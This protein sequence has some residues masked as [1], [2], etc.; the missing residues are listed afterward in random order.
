M[1]FGRVATLVDF[2]HVTMKLNHHQSLDLS[3]PA[4]GGSGS[5]TA[6]IVL[7]LPPSIIL[8]AQT[9]SEFQQFEDGCVEVSYLGIFVLGSSI[10]ITL[11]TFKRF[12]GVLSSLYLIF[13]F[14]KME[15]Q[16][17]PI[18]AVRGHRIVSSFNI[19]NVFRFQLMKRQSG[20]VVWFLGLQP[21]GSPDFLVRGCGAYAQSR[22]S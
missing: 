10:V 14:V 21:T 2:C 9:W 20:E 3:R 17:C 7:F 11:P 22:R 1:V 12:N 16:R 15:C 13:W 4:C 8:V 5:A 18:S 6:G 19:G